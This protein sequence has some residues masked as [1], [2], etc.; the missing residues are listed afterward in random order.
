MSLIGGLDVFELS[1][2]SEALALKS[3]ERG[4][5]GLALG[6]GKLGDF[7]EKTVLEIVELLPSLVDPAQPLFAL[8]PNFT[9]EC[10]PSLSLAVGE[11]AGSGFDSGRPSNW[12]ETHE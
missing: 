2:L 9:P 3:A 6:L 5:S 1:E 11:L 7:G 12:L 10:G 8:A 4:L